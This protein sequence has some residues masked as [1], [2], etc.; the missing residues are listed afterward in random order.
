MGEFNIEEHDQQ[1]GGSTDMGDVSYTIPAIHP[2]VKFV[3]NGADA[4]FRIYECFN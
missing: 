2:M 1:N 4:H 3:E